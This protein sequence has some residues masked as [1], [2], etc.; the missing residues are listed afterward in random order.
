MQTVYQNLSVINKTTGK[1]P[2]FPGP[3]L[4]HRTERTVDYQ[5]FWQCITRFRSSLKDI[6]ILGSDECKEMYDGLRCN[7]NEPTLL[8]GVEHV[9]KNVQRKLSDLFFPQKVQRAILDGIF[10]DRGL[11]A[12]ES[13]EKFELLPEMLLKWDE[14]EQKYTK[15]SSDFSSYSIE[16]KASIVR[17]HMLLAVR[18]HARFSGSYRQNSI[19]WNH[20]MTKNEVDAGLPGFHKKDSISNVIMKLKERS[21]RM[22]TN[23]VK[24][25]YGK[26]DVYELSGRYPLQ[27]K[28]DYWMDRNEEERKF[29]TKLLFTSLPEI[30]VGSNQNYSV[31][32][33]E[34]DIELS[35]ISSP[36]QGGAPD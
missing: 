34:D 14:L 25:M 10:G 33:A 29:V 28:Y 6:A 24:A 13:K 8:F 3:I 15:S 2:W 9:E 31:I 18:N 11:I 22:F 12:C 26:S 17:D 19:E 36:V 30:P 20:F 7:M 16:H 4:V 1:H 35:A 21:I 5:Y 23:V 27:I 32:C